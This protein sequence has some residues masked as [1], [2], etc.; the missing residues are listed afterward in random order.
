L[1]KK[2]P[3]TEKISENSSEPLVSLR[4]KQNTEGDL[5]EIIIEKQN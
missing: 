1:P 5:P 3:R 4:P 2:I